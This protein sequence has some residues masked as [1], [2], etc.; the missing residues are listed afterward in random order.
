MHAILV[1]DALPTAS[2]CVDIFHVDPTHS[3]DS[4]ERR[5]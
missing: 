3:R 4:V 5:V 1:V 2:P